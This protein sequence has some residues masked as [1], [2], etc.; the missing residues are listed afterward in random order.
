MLQVAL[1]LDLP[2]QLNLNVMLD[3]VALVQDL[4]SHYELG[5]LLSRKVNVA[6]LAFTKR[7]SDFEIIN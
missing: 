1:N 2:A 6:K 7:F 5:L 3:E 4:D